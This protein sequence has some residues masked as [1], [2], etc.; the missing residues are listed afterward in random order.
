MKGGNMRR[1]SF[2]LACSL[3]LISPAFSGAAEWCGFDHIHRGLMEADPEYRTRVFEQREEI[4]R[5]LRNRSVSDDTIYKIPVVVH[6]LHL[7]EPVGTGS[8][9][10][11]EQVR[12]AITVLNE[13]FRKMAGTNGEGNGVD[14]GIEFCLAVRDPD[15]QPTSGIVRVYAGGVGSGLTSYA[16]YGLRTSINGQP[17]QQEYDLKDL[18]RWNNSRYYNIWVVTEIDDNN[19][20]F[21]TMGFAYLPPADPEIDGMVVV[22]K[23]V[24]TVGTAEGTLSR[25]VTHEMGHA[26][27][28]YHTF[29]G[30][31]EGLAGEITYEDLQCP[32]DQKCGSSGDCIDDTDPHIRSRDDCRQTDSNECVPG[33]LLGRLVHNYMDYSSE[34]CQNEFTAGQRERMRTA[35]QSSRSSLLTL[36]SNGCVA[37]TKPVTDFSAPTY[38]C[39]GNISFKDQSTDGPTSWSWTFQGGDPE[40]STE[41]N[42]TVDYDTPG[43]YEVTLTAFNSIGE[44]TTKKQSITFYNSPADACSVQTNNLGTDYGMGIYNVTFGDIDNTTGDSI[45]DKGYQDFSCSKTTLLNP[46]QT[47]DISVTVGTRNFE[48]VLVFIDFNNDGNF[49]SDEKVFE[50]FSKTDKISGKITTPENPVPDTLLRMRVISDYHASIDLDACTNPEDGQAED[51]GIVFKSTAPNPTPQIAIGNPSS[52]ITANNAVSYTVTYTD[53]ETVTLSADNIT[54]NKTATA[55]A[56]IG[57]SGTGTTSRTATLSDIS[58][59]GT[60][61][62]TIAAGTATNRGN[63]APEATGDTFKVDNTAPAIAITSPADSATIT[64]TT[65]LLSFQVT[66]ENLGTGTTTVKVDDVTVS[67]NSGDALDELENGSYTVAVSHTDAAGNSGSADSTFTIDTTAPVMKGDIVKNNVIDL[68]D[69][70]TALKILADIPLDKP[71]EMAAEVDGNSAIDM[72]EAIFILQWVSGLRDN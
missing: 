23:A 34:T 62:I 40:T 56:T 14:T 19:G 17:T 57:V 50:S 68:E 24:G 13:D 64:D 8:N 5:L 21:G 59:D 49:S 61:G 11:D 10:S 28:L 29:E 46:S 41:Q 70:I 67:K 43:T 32:S 33:K 66:E 15:D 48:N 39:T 54:L 18:S 9:I 16:D 7:G 30:D 25:T 69:A 22:H 3:L 36:T 27:G 31:A 35:I 63:S 12:S 65:P 72:K 58:G 6:I 45:D 42:P 1:L 2:W 4:A 71:V 51:Y 52:S 47:Y 60:L 26:M 53:A 37:V 44:G 55:T 20:K 38:A